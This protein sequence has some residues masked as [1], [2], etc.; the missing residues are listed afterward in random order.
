MHVT[1]TNRLA[2]ELAWLHD[3]EQMARGLSAWPSARTAPYGGW[4]AGLWKAWLLSSGSGRQLELL[5]PSAERLVW[6]EVIGGHGGHG[7]YGRANRR[8]GD[9]AEALDVFG[10]FDTRATAGVAMEA[11]SLLSE[12]DLPIDDPDAA[13]EWSDTP[14]TETFLAWVRDFRQRLGA[15]GWITASQLPRFIGERLDALEIAISGPVEFSGFLDRTPARAFLVE[16]LERAGVRTIESFP[17]AIDRSNAGASA[18]RALDEADEVRLAARW[19]RREL[20]RVMAEGVPSPA[21]R[22]PVGIV[23]PELSRYRSRLE[24]VLTETFHPETRLDPG[25]DPH[26]AFNLSLGPAFADH[27]AVAAALRVL[28]CRPDRIGLEDAGALLRSPFLRGGRSESSPRAAIDR[29]LG[30]RREPEVAASHILRLARESA[31]P[32]PELIRALTLWSRE[33]TDPVPD[34]AP[35]RWASTFSSILGALGWPGDSPIPSALY[36]TVAA[37]EELLREF[38]GLDVVAGRMDRS[39]AVRVLGRMAAERQ[40]QVEGERAPVQVLGILEAIGMRFDR[41]WVMG[42][43]DTAWPRRAAPNPFLP[44]VL[45]KRFGLPR[46]SPEIELETARTIEN[47]LLGSA[48]RTLVSFPG[49]SGDVECRPCLFASALPEVGR[50]LVGE[51]GPEYSDVLRRSAD[52]EILVDRHAPKWD[53]PLAS[54]GASVFSDQA[55]C[56]FRAFAVHRMGAV[57]L[58]SAEPGLGPRE[59]GELVHRTLESVWSRIHSHADLAA[60]SD[61]EARDLVEWAADQAIESLAR[62]R[63]VLRDEGF[64]GV[65]RRRLTRLVVEWLELE[66]RRAPF[67]VVGREDQDAVEVG[68]V[69]VRL[70]PDRVDRVV[71]GTLVV[72]DYKTADRSPRRWFGDRPDEPQLPL[73]AVTTTVGPVGGVYFGRLRPGRVAFRGIA[74]SPG[75]APGTEP[76]PRPMSEIVDRWREVLESLGRDFL[77]GE[78]GVDPKGPE[79]CRYCALPGLCRIADAGRDPTVEREDR[80]G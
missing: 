13:L 32:L 71:D 79:T 46:S 47:A 70:R 33:Y 8:N 18:V 37:W 7:G 4:L 64:A 24:R 59:R 26:R 66:R 49:R 20:E 30:E 42:A 15:R 11:W 27:P 28:G 72:I 31:A 74:D 10:V 76:S 22:V 45:Q 36:Q 58:E 65:E 5:A 39:R 52:P 29:K 57:P 53:D 34:P 78:A 9:L 35:S 6:E 55:R 17:G 48:R 12:W 40:F 80:H 23:V 73:Y 25:A 14:D 60:L 68:G 75:I 62:Q 63:A 50:E 77:N 38:S 61:E 51:P 16:A 41:L 1:A 2:R 69:R 44:V 21:G 19:A 56:G 67:A 54:G 43:D 3:R